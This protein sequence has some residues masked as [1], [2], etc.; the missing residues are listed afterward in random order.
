[1]LSRRFHDPYLRRVRFFFTR[2]EKVVVLAATPAPELREQVRSSAQNLPGTYRMIGEDG[3]VLYV[4]KSKAVRTRLLS[5]FRAK[6]G[7]KAYRLVREAARVEF[8]YEP[9]EFAALLR[10]LQLIKRYRPRFNVR[11]RRDAIYSFLKL[12]RGPAPRLFVVRQVSDDAATYFGP[13]RAGRRIAEGVREL[14]DVLGLRDCAQT[15]PIH[16][17]DQ[18]EIFPMERTPRCHRFEL[19]LCAG[20]CAAGCTRS[21]YLQTVALARDFLDGSGDEPLRRVRERMEGAVERLE[22]EYAASLRDRLLRLEMLQ[23]EF[24]RLREAL[25]HLTFQY[26]LPGTDGDDR[27]YLVRRGTVRA[28]MAAPRTKRQR[29]RADRIAREVLETPEATGTMVSTR[30]VEEILLLAHWFRSRPEELERTVPLDAP[31]PVAPRRRKP[32]RTRSQSSVQPASGISVAPPAA[33][34]P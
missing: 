19:S 28:E 11:Y 6:E 4:G 15:I 5:Y 31:A 33:P 29:E 27:L 13:F 10:E 25:D 22:F 18:V 9:N 20:P 23:E 16:Y 21:E 24:G 26:L 2:R 17:A 12:S 34:A 1:M 8:E 7:E 14:N 32:R 3:E 30:K